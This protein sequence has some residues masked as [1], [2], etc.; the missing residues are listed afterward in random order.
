[1]IDGEGGR[2]TY[3]KPGSPR[4]PASVTATTKGEADAPVDCLL[5]KD[6]LFEL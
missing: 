1:M 4:M 3:M 5:A 6:R 2:W